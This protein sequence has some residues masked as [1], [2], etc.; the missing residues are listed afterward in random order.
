MTL[1]LLVLYVRLLFVTETIWAGWPSPRSSAGRHGPRPT[2]PLLEMRLIAPCTKLPSLAL[3]RNSGRKSQE[4]RPQHGA[5]KRKTEINATS[6]PSTNLRPWRCLFSRNQLSDIRWL[7]SQCRDISSYPADWLCNTFIHSFI[8]APVPVRVG[9]EGHPAPVPSTAT[10][11]QV[12]GP[13]GR[14]RRTIKSH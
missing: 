1:L 6:F 11:I 7:H 13:P 8:H 3:A 10:S 14:G 9:V 5:P 12:V 4:T 2:G